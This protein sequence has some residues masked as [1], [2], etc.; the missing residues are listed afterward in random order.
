MKCPKC[1][2]ESPEGAQYCVE[3][4]A[5]LEA[6]CPKCGFANSP[7]YKFCAK[8][9]QP[10]T[11]AI[12]ARPEQAPEP[13]PLPTSFA[14]NR[15]QIKE[16][17]GEGGRKRVY[18]AHDTLLD[19]DVALGL[20]RT[21]GLDEDNRLRVTREAQ[22][23]G[24]LGSHQNIVVVHDFGDEDGQP[25]IVQELM[26]GDV[27]DLIEEAEDQRLP[28][29]QVVDIATSVCQGLGFAHTKGIIHRDLKPGNVFISA[30]GIYKIGDFGLALVDDHTRLTQTDG[31]LGT[32]LYSS[33]EQ[34]SGGDVAVR[35]DL[36]SVG[37]MVYE[38]VTGRPPFVGD[39]SVSIVGQHI[40]SPPVE[41]SFHRPDV[42]RALEVLI[43]RLLE[44]DPEKRPATASDVLSALMSVETAEAPAPPDT[45]APPDI[46]P[47][48]RRVFVGREAE[49]K[50]LKGAF[51]DAC[52]GH[53]SFAMVVGEPG[54]GKTALCEELKTY[55]GVRGG[56]TLVG[57]CYEEGSLSLPYLAFVEAMR[58][59]VL[60]RDPDDLREVLGTG[61]THVG[62]IVSEIGDRLQIELPEP[63]NPEEERYRLMQS[64]SEFLTHAASLQPMLI[65]LEDLHDADQETLDMLAFVS[66]QLPDTRMLIV[67]NYRDVEVDRAHPLSK[68]LAELRRAANYNRILLR[69]LNADE[70]Q[71]MLAAIT[72]QDMAWGI[73]EGVHRQTEGNP[74]FVQEVLRHLVEEG[75][76]SR[77]GG[78]WGVVGQSDILMRIPEGLRDVIGK[79][80]SLLSA[81]CNHLLSIAAV[82]GREFR[83]RVLREVADVPEDD[84]LSVLEEA[85]AMAVVEELPSV[86]GT[87]TYRFTHAY[88][89]QTLY[90][91]M[92][93]PR[94][95]RLHQQIAMVLEKQYGSRL[96]DHAAELAEHFSHSTDTADLRKAVDY[97]G[98]AAKQALTVFAFGEAVRLQE[99]AVQVQEVLDPDDKERRC[100][101]LLTLADTL[102]YAGEARRVLDVAAPAALSLAEESGNQGQASQACFL[103][104][105]A[106][107]RYGPGYLGTGPAMRSSEALEWAGRADRHAKPG[108]VD[109]DLADAFL[110]RPIRHQR[111]IELAR[112]TG[113]YETLWL[114]T[115]I[116]GFSGDSEERLQQA[117]ELLEWPRQNINIQTLASCLYDVIYL[118]I[119][120][121][122][123]ER[124]EE[125]MHEVQELADRT[126]QPLCVTHSMFYGALIAK[127]DG[128]LTD[129]RGLSQDM[130]DYGKGIN[131]TDETDA[132]SHIASLRPRVYLGDAERFLNVCLNGDPNPHARPF[133][134]C[135]LGRNEEAGEALQE[136]IA[137]PTE[138]RL[139]YVVMLLE[140][141]VLLG[142]KDALQQLL[143]R[144]PSSHPSTTGLL[145]TTCV[146]R[147]L[148]A[149]A[150]F[151]N[152]PHEARAHYQDALKLATDMRFRPE[153]ALTRHQMAELLLE[154]YPDER[155][156]ALEHLDFAIEEFKEMKM[157]PYIEKAE[158][159]KESL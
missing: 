94:R 78:R 156:E 120:R 6:T 129:V 133:Y 122:S 16:P 75:H 32:F 119:S 130:R 151:L 97:G 23:M 4:G 115:S 100:D 69:G 149:A 72:R 144:L 92:I 83:L 12:P 36:Y 91:E 61:A 54:I 50:Q 118:F 102:L 10:L 19:R 74:L 127:L 71:R 44:K 65:V 93:A 109:R 63:A 136:L 45:E 9:G 90:E 21:E 27:A 155:D 58:S 43:L 49:L 146:S 70:V 25:Y 2:F 1:Q 80:L 113:N 62:R 26:D 35:S 159:L 141:A 96:R 139:C 99:Q 24:R 105:L 41:P 116:A 86:A 126:R 145:Y 30:D 142:H 29:E 101:L 110:G 33:P 103:A 17:I 53:G 64:V 46:S 31:V 81:E 14:D 106:L 59:Y 66:R 143:E 56:Q 95:N 147:H 13:S 11:N 60:E 104:L 47:I 79:R 135:L 138:I 73:A 85:R 107:A 55:V 67:G 18:L 42:P 3:C 140:T 38:M 77:K 51:D 88:F 125:I 20:I 123:R 7:T 87:V 89:R 52:S 40:N 114:T 131:M 124:A 128:R 39:D 111:A 5:R 76:M 112:T 34:A 28:I 98:M 134:L 132:W 15:Y 84:L 154:H 148:G 68:A 121:G 150:A 152:E 8:C 57:H 82:I 157:K 48:Y 158:A 22:A 117:E 37:A 137:D 108:T 153:L